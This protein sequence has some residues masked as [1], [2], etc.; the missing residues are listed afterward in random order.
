ME[1]KVII[2]I[3]SPQPMWHEEW[4]SVGDSGEECRVQ[5]I[6]FIGS[7]EEDFLDKYQI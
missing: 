6:F 7:D 5:V 4:G 1:G 3:Q 2:Q